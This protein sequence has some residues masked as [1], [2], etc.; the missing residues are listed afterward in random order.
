MHCLHC[1][2]Y[3][4]AQAPCGL[5]SRSPEKDWGRLYRHSRFS[6]SV[7]SGVLDLYLGFSVDF[8][9]RTGIWVVVVHA[10][11]WELFGLCHPRFPVGGHFALKNCVRPV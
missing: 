10:G 5:V 7:E 11:N 1:L 8:L 3:S 6:H 9:S 4:H 2:I